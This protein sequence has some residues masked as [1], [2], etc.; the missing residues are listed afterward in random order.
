MIISARVS[1]KS[2]Y[3]SLSER[4]G[5]SKGVTR[6]QQTLSALWGGLFASSCAV[7]AHQDIQTPVAIDAP[8]A[9]LKGTR[10]VQY[11]VGVHIEAPASIVWGLLTDAAEYPNWNRS[12]KSIKGSIAAHEKIRLVSSA[13]PDRSFKLKVIEF[14]P[15]RKMVW[16]SGGRAFG[17]ERVFTLKAI[18]PNQT[19]FTMTEN[20]GGAMMG[21][22]EK[23]LPDLRESF[24]TF[25]QDLKRTAQAQASRKNA[26]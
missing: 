22:I 25:A 11:R 20:L 5:I 6:L 9:Q 21:M 13:S 3:Y 12:V 1:S 16:G 24:D 7:S 19:Q 26:P 10:H 14:Q 8:A 18:G 15:E 23:K 17:G 2:T 4:R